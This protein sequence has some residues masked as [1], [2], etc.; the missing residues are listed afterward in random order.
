MLPRQILKV[1]GLWGKKQKQRQL[2]MSSL[3][4]KK[5]K[6]KMC[7]NLD[8]H[9]NILLISFF[10]TQMFCKRLSSVLV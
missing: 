6:I 7:L 5:N 2:G 10:T 1:F 8:S 3:E 9:L 4:K